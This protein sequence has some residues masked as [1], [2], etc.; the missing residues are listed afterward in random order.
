VKIRRNDG[1]RVARILNNLIRERNIMCLERMNKKNTNN[2][3]D[4][5]RVVV[6]TEGLVI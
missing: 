4:G 3:T 5:W 1:R 6:S 2:I